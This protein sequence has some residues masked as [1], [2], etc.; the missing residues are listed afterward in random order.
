MVTDRFKVIQTILNVARM[1]VTVKDGLPVVAYPLGKRITHVNSQVTFG[2]RYVTKKVRVVDLPYGGANV[3]S[4]ISFL[5]AMY[6]LARDRRGLA[7]GVRRLHP[8]YV[9][10]LV[11]GWKCPEAVVLSLWMQKG[12]GGV[13]GTLG[14]SGGVFC[15]QREPWRGRGYGQRRRRRRSSLTLGVQRGEAGG[16]ESRRFGGK[17]QRRHSRHARETWQHRV[18]VKGP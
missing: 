4:R 10:V 1:I 8:W 16:T 11:A 13:T 18:H 5:D 3:E 6:K 7:Q 12:G 17:G 14:G 15:T 2:P 9:G